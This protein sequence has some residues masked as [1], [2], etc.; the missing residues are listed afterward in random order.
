MYS[1]TKRRRTALLAAT[2]ASL[3][4]LA[5]AC[6]TPNG[7]GAGPTSTGTS[8]TALT[9]TQGMLL[10]SNGS[11]QVVVGDKTIDFSTTVTDAAWSPDGSRI[12]FINGDGNVATA[13]P[14]GSD[15]LVLTSTDSSVV[16]SRPSWSREVLF[17]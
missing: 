14:D 4:V 12:A 7:N 2:A 15:V 11:K 16:R 8:D 10:L 3:A 9:V 6:A 1:S 17:Y 13:K 5:A